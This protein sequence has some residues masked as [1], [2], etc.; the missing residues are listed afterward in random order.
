MALRPPSAQQT[1]IGSILVSVNP[2]QMFRI[3]RLEQVQQYNGRALGENPLHLFAIANLTFAK[4]LYAKQNQCIIISGESSS[5]KT[6]ATKLILHYLAAMNQKRDVMQQVLAF[7]REDQDSIFCI[8]A[9]ILHLG[10]IYFEK[11]EGH[12][13]GLPADMEIEP[14]EIHNRTDWF[15]I[16]QL[17]PELD[18]TEPV[19][20]GGRHPD[21]MAPIPVQALSS[22][23]L[24][25]S[26]T[27]LPPV[28]SQEA[29]Q[30][31]QELRRKIKWMKML[32]EWEKY[33]NSEK[34]TCGGRGPG[35]TLCRDR[36]QTP[37]A[38]AWH[39]QPLRGRAGT[40]SSHR[41]SQAWSKALLPVGASITLL[42]GNSWEGRPCPS[43]ISPLLRNQGAKTND[44]QNS[45]VLVLAGVAPGPSHQII[46]CPQLVRRVYKGIPMNIRGQVWS[47]LLNIDDIKGKNPSTYQ[48]R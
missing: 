30:I 37:V 16:V 10:N 46:F 41:G 22:A 33:K 47:V 23:W 27:E 7:S 26:E 17:S 14:V 6:E 39:P 45:R 9:S 19:L 1:H 8:L 2:Y 44:L 29:K 15:G 5:G 24:P 35:T 25:Y 38:V 31:R 13:A 40:L 18:E 48:V 20:S 3:Y 32:G 11:Y 21:R 12:R 42:E 28:S 43:L 34:V 4:M 36:G